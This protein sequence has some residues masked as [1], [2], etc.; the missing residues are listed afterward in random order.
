[1]PRKLAALAAHRSQVEFL[2]AGV[3]QQVTLAG[4]DVQAMFGD[5]ANDPLALLA[6]GMQTQAAEVGQQIGVTF[7]EAFRY[8]RFHALVEGMLA[9]G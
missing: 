8:E 2:V 6:W 3:L 7:G 9:S 5:A 1:M 4:L